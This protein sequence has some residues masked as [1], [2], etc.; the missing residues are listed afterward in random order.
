VQHPNTPP[1]VVATEERKA[2]QLKQERTDLTSNLQSCLAIVKTAKS[3]AGHSDAGRH[4]ALVQT[5]IEEAL[6]WNVAEAVL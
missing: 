5:K 4:L 3:L 6:L 1:E 2:K